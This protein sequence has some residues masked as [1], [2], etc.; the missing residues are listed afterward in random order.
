M[1]YKNSQKKK[2]KIG[3]DAFSVVGVLELLHAKSIARTAKYKKNLIDYSILLKLS[4]QC[5]KN[6]NSSAGFV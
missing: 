3:V 4:H 6:L 5:F 2:F 1:G